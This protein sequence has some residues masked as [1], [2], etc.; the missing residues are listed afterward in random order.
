MPLVSLPSAYLAPSL[1]HM[2]TVG[3]LDLS[4]WLVRSAQCGP[5]TH[6]QKSSGWIF[7]KVYRRSNDV[8]ITG[9][10]LFSL[11]SG[12]STCSATS[13]LDQHSARLLSSPLSFHFSPCLLKPSSLFLVSWP[14]R[15]SVQSPQALCLAPPRPTTNSTRDK[16]A[17]RICGTCSSATLSWTPAK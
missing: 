3:D 2:N 9:T 4:L 5:N 6:S 14:P 1:L 16:S 11:L 15:Q 13:H 8:V 7:L 17:N 10:R 12:S